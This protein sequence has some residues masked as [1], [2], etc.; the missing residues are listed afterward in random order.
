MDLCATQPTEGPTRLRCTLGKV[1][2]GFSAP[3]SRTQHIFRLLQPPRG[4]VEQRSL[5]ILSNLDTEG[6]LETGIWLISRMEME[7][8]G[9]FAETDKK[10]ALAAAQRVVCCEAA[11]GTGTIGNKM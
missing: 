4:T 10:M 2:T 9:H 8:G 1:Q 6:H 5:L 3:Q 7:G 11:M